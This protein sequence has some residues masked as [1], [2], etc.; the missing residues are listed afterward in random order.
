VR[1]AA[2]SLLPGALLV[3]AVLVAYAPAMEAGYVW[4]DD[5]HVTANETLRSA[6]GART[7]ASALGVLGDLSRAENHAREALRLD[8]EIRELLRREPEPVE[9]RFNLGL[10]ARLGRGDEARAE[11]ERLRLRP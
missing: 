5:A 10:V 1:Q 8:P 7:T 2:A 6:N 3:A 4:D 9:T 11:A